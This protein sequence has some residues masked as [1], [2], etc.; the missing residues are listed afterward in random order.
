[1]LQK[2]DPVTGSFYTEVTTSVTTTSTSYVDLLSLTATIGANAVLIHYSVSANNSSVAN[3]SISFRLT[4]DGTAVRGSG[5]R[6][7]ANNLGN[8]TAL[9]YKTAV[10]AAGSHTFKLQWLTEALTTAQVRPSTNP[11]EHASLLITEVTI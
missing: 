10:L 6:T 8:S 9:V 5:L 1:M 3:R 4:V 7:D 2:Q 11:D